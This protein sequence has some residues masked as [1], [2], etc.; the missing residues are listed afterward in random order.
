MGSVCEF[1]RHNETRLYAVVQVENCSFSS[2]GK[3]LCTGPCLIFHI[4]KCSKWKTKVEV[5]THYLCFLIC[6][7][8][9]HA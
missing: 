8:V 1:P 7:L 3:D 2:W 6:P 4:A 9:Q 5:K